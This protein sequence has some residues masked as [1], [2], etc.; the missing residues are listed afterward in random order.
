VRPVIAFDADVAEDDVI[1]DGVAEVDVQVDR[2]PL[3][4][5]VAE[6]PQQKVVVAERL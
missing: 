2:D 5:T 1:G 3:P 6:V 4:A